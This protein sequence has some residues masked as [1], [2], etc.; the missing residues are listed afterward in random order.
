MQCG[1]S[2]KKMQKGGALR[3]LG[4][5]IGVGVN[6]AGMVGTGIKAISDRVKAKKAEKKEKEAALDKKQ[7]GGVTPTKGKES[8]KD[9]V[10]RYSPMSSDKAK[11]RGLFSKPKGG[12]RGL[13]LDEKQKGGVTKNLQFY[14]DGSL[15][16]FESERAKQ[17]KQGGLRRD[18][19]YN[20]IR[21][22]IEKTTGKKS[23][24][25]YQKGGIAKQEIVGMPGYNARTD[26]MKSGGSAKK[27][28]LTKAQAG[29]VVG[30]PKKM[31]DRVRKGPGVPPPTPMD[32]RKSPPDAIYK[33][34]DPGFN[35]NPKTPYRNTDPGFIKTPNKPYRN[36]DP[37]FSKTPKI[38]PGNKDV[39]KNAGPPP[40]PEGYKK[41][42]ATNAKKK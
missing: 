10:K 18:D 22:D 35:V 33:N 28:T 20:K 9:F 25:K 41:G 21:E 8:V 17:P 4:S 27:K 23:S 32:V 12:S 42:G 34:M 39:F 30:N 15:K 1:G 29:R 3:T 24:L 26:T 38:N 36:T 31:V 11:G 14:K 2:T 37:G 13:K 19:K 16:T 5:K 7:M 6:V 40:Q